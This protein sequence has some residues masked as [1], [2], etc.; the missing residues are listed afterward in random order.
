MILSSH[1]NAVMCIVGE[2]K[3]A[4]LEEGEVTQSQTS[5]SGLSWLS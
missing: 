2:K 4:V 3:T 5:T 1:A